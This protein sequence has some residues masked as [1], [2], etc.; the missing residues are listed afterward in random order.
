[1]HQVNV[2]RYCKKILVSYSHTPSLYRSIADT[3]DLL[4]IVVS[5][6]YGIMCHHYYNTCIKT[7]GIA[8]IN[9]GVP[10]V[11]YTREYLM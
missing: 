4:K 6:Q 1:M 3:M 9:A 2:I 11:R 8:S 5:C 7:Y 10:Y